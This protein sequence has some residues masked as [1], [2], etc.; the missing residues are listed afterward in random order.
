MATKKY[1]I[2]IK[3]GEYE[4]NGETKGRWV[5]VG[6]VMQGDN[7]FFALLDPGVNLAAYKEQGKDKVIASL[8]EAN[9]QQQ[10]PQQPQQDPSQPADDIDDDLPF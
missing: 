5:N 10:A 6:A 3:A 4:K 1:D 2:A 7:G 8:F 9:R